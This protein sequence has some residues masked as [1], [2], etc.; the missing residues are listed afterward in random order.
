[1]DGNKVNIHNDAQQYVKESSV[2]ESQDQNSADSPPNRPKLFILNTDCFDEILGW[3]SQ[4]NLD[5]LGQ[6]CKLLRCVVGDY[7]KRNYAATEVQAE[8]D[9]LYVSDPHKVNTYRDRCKL[10]SFDK[11][12]GKVS[13]C[14]NSIDIED[15]LKMFCYVGTH[16]GNSL[17]HIQFMNVLLTHTELEWVTNILKT[18]E[19]VAIE[20]CLIKRTFYERFPDVCCNLRNL[21]VQD[22]RWN[23]NVVKH[24][25]KWLLHKYP[26]LERLGWSQSV[27]KDRKIGELKTF[28]QLNPNI[29]GFRTSFHCFWS[30][31]DALVKSHLQLT[32]LTIEFDDWTWTPNN[33]HETYK[34]LN[35]LHQRKI[36]KRLHFFARYYNQ[37]YFEQMVLLVGLHSLKLHEISERYTLPQLPQLKELTIRY[38][39]TDLGTLVGK[40]ENVERIS[41]KYAESKHF[42]PFVYACPALKEMKIDVVTD[43]IQFDCI[44][45]LAKINGE[46]GKMPNARK[47]TIYID[48]SVFL[49]TKWV[50]P[51]E[52]KFVEIRRAQSYEWNHQV[53]FY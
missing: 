33:I 4:E 23:R 31:R 17:K 13:I 32:D 40:F 35:E 14:E 51:T 19:T 25:N 43:R 12:V 18:I 37:Q 27:R 30:N 9:G 2:Q 48:E 34:L 52:W 41:F 45:D 22:S 21:Y 10:H 8:D 26:K 50:Q 36:Y 53:E 46:R 44:L 42:L 49:A 16:C 11:C 1:M 29:I 39:N 24:S 20:D 47:L 28:F 6:T 3:L 15:G 38:I 7:F 5:A